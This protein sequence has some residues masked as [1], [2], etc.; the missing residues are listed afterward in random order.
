MPGVPCP[1]N[2]FLSQVLQYCSVGAVGSEQYGFGV[3]WLTIVSTSVALGL[4]LKKLLATEELVLMP[5]KLNAVNL[6]VLVRQNI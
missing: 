1:H 2:S 4:L 6:N 5:I 3:D